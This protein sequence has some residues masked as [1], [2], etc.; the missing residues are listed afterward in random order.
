[1]SLI[2]DGAIEIKKK[3]FDEEAIAKRVKELGAQI[4]EDFRGE[5]LVVIGVIKGSVYFF[6]D[7]TRAIDLPIK[8]DMIG[9]GNIPD[10]TGF[11][12]PNEY[13]EKI[14]YLYE[15]VDAFAAGKCIL[16]THCH[17]DLGMATA[18]T[19]AGVLAGARQVEVTVNGIGERAGN[20]SL[21]EVAMIFKTHPD[22]GITTNIN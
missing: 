21:E 1:M 6:S 20:T 5:E 8:I 17:N 13:H 19:V 22:L 4:T 16:S 2:L 10:T 3:V 18:N 15:H 12:V 7:L 9:F 11:R 14:K